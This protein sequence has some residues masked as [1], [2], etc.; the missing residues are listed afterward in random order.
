MDALAHKFKAL[1]DVQSRVDILKVRQFFVR[2]FNVS[3]TQIQ[4]IDVNNKLPDTKWLQ[5]IYFYLFLK[6]QEFF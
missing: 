2:F 5:I 3:N 4:K 6:I 1:Y